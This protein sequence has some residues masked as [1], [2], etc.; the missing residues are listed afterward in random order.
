MSN[1]YVMWYYGDAS[2]VEA[3]ARTVKWA[4]GPGGEANGR[5]EFIT[6]DGVLDAAQVEK[7]YVAKLMAGEADAIM[8]IKSFLSTTYFEDCTRLHIAEDI[9]FGDYSIF[10]VFQAE[11]S[12]LANDWM[13]ATQWFKGLPRYAELRARHLR[14]GAPCLGGNRDAN[15]PAVSLASQS[16]VFVISGTLC[17]LGLILG[18]VQLVSKRYWIT[19]MEGESN[20]GDVLTTDG[21]MLRAVLT[22]LDALTNGGHHSC[23]VIDGPQD[24]QAA[25]G[26]MLHFLQAI[27]SKLN[28]LTNHIHQDDQTLDVPTKSSWAVRSMPARCMADREMDERKV[29]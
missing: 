26:Q 21:E 8:Q 16:G 20:E 12:K 6:A 3:F 29:A 5:P 15:E 27:L 4:L 28:V 25:D 9:Q 7:W 17:A 13:V 10:L 23:H 11:D 19:P 1:V 14:I 2:Q 22:K 18:L 24:V